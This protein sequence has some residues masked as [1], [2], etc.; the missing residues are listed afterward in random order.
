[1]E[2]GGV[3]TLLCEAL[4]DG[5]HLPVVNCSPGL[6]VSGPQMRNEYGS[7]KIRVKLISK[8]QRP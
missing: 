7:G 2:V 5:L 3:F 8:D 4:S 6:A 1:M